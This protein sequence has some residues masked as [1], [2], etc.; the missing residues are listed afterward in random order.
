MTEPLIIFLCEGAAAYDLAS[1]IEHAAREA[2]LSAKAEGV[3]GT[4]GNKVEPNVFVSKNDIIRRPDANHRHEPDG[5]QRQQPQQQQQ[6]SWTDT[7]QVIVAGSVPIAAFA[8]FAKNCL[9]IFIKTKG[10][11]HP[12]KSIEATIDGRKITIN[13][14]DEV[15]DIVRRYDEST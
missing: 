4:S 10:L 2:G 11:L 12:P 7:W 9:D 13:A 14:G 3:F 6:Q 5:Q 1:S 8:V 15:R